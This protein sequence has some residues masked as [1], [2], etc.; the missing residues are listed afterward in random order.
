MSLS[1][2]TC[3]VSAM[4]S[5]MGGLEPAEFG[6]FT[7][8]AANEITVCVD[9]TGVSPGSDRMELELVLPMPFAAA[10]AAAPDPRLAAMPLL[11][12]PR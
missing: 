1:E 9:A 3:T 12:G 10:M 8:L 7:G 4:W 5:T 11:R 6:R 2:Y